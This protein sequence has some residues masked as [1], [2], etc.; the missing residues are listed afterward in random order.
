MS[1]QSNDWMNPPNDNLNE[2]DYFNSLGTVKTSNKNVKDAGIS[3][4]E[5]KSRKLIKRLGV[6]D[7]N[8]QSNQIK[9][10]ATSNVQL[11]GPGYQWRLMKLKRTLEAAREENRPIEE[12]AFERYGS[13]DAWNQAL[14]ERRF[15]EQ[16]QSIGSS[17]SQTNSPIKTSSDHEL[18]FIFS[19]NN[20]AQSRSSSRSSFR[21]PTSSLSTPNHHH[22]DKS[23]NKPGQTP[24]NSISY[25]NSPST[26]STPIPSVIDPITNRIA[27]ATPSNSKSVN[28]SLLN[29]LQ[30][31]LL[32][33]KMMNPEQVA[34]LEEQY[35]NALEAQKTNDSA[36]QVQMVP[37]LD[38]RGRMYDNGIG[39]EPEPGP[40]RPGNK[41]RKEAKFQTRDPKTGELIRY[42]PDDDQL[43]LREM[44]R[45]ERFQAGADDQ[46]NM[47]A[48]M[49]SRIMADGHFENDL[50]Y[51]DDNADRL[52]RKKMRTEASKRLFAHN[53]YA[54]TKKAL[55]TCHFCFQDNGSPPHNL[56]IVSSG[57]RVYLC[58]PEFEELVDGHCW[59]VPIE[60]FLCS[61]EADDD[62]WE[63]I[64]NYMKCL[65]K[66][67]AEKHDKGV[68]FY[69]TVLSFKHQKHSYIEAVP[70]SW[71]LLEDIP[72]YF[73]QSILSS[74]SEWSQHR[75]L[76][77]F[78]DRPG[79]FRKSMVSKLPYFMVTWDYKGAKGYGHVIE[80]N[81]ESSSRG[82]RGDNDLE[83]VETI[84]DEAGKGEKFPRYFAAEIIG[85]LLQLEPRKWRK[86]KRIDFKLKDKRVN[87][88]LNTIGY[89]KFDWTGLI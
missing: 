23:F 25:S 83:Q 18:K 62:V 75:K 40:S 43:S 74:E 81:E 73:K 71:D 54:R 78:A 76:I 5:D 85:N 57:T 41:R 36:T 19:A 13:I 61:L 14:E 1:S 30:A 4:Q 89:S 70:V 68:I 22:N 84:I 86:P 33:A 67:F 50:D 20:N 7:P 27:L 80:G 58:C 42:N 2:D 56:A 55:E 32:K 12:I 34:E 46:K 26:P 37:S 11:G 45:Q 53:D 17:T 24:S 88:F 10:I 6:D 52:A 8:Y 72:G 49:A 15:V 39:N 28:S 87:F 16:R 66:M 21:K 47:D 79:G 29:K 31:K 3:R 9:S 59:I 65:M 44:V 63:E 35:Q 82:V 64:K 38:G 51:M 48:E 60:H 69:E 77:N